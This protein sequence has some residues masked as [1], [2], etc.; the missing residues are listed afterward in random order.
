MIFNIDEIKGKMDAENKTPYMNVFLQEIEYM[1]ILL[2]E[3]V[4]SLEEIN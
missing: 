2:I 1:N 4:R 3:L